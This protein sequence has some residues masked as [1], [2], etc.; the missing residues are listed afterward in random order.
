M[1]D[2]C[3]LLLEGSLRTYDYSWYT[4]H[5]RIVIDYWKVLFQP[6][7]EA[8]T[9][10]PDGPLLVGTHI[11]Q[12]ENTQ[13]RTNRRMEL[14]SEM[15]QKMDTGVAPEAKRRASA[16]ISA[17]ESAM[18]G[19]PAFEKAKGACSLVRCGPYTGRA[20]RTQSRTRTQ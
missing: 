4:V 1:C 14:L 13:F 19:Y 3:V 10:D 17:F 15:L 2:S 11:Q 8:C 12:I 18:K 9:G 5:E 6:Q 20:I 16:F 7:L